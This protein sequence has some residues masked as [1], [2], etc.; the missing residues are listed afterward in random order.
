[1]KGRYVLLTAA[2]NEA[3]FIEGAIRSVAEQTILPTSWIIVDDG[4]SDRTLEIARG[5]A[6]HLPWLTVLGR[7]KRETGFA[8]KV[9]SLNWAWEVTKG[10]MADSPADFVGVVDADVTFPPLHFERLMERMFREQRLGLAGGWVCEPREGRFE[11]RSGNREH[12]VPG[13]CQ[14]FRWELFERMGGFLPL[15]WG[16]EDWAAELFIRSLGYEVRSFPELAVLHHKPTVPNWRAGWRTAFRQGR[17]D[18]SLGCG[19]LFHLARALRRI[20]QPPPVLSFLLRLSGYLWERT[21]GQCLLPAE[22]RSYFVAWQRRR[23]W[24]R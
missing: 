18:A 8:S 15:P 24:S 6:E 13:C 20:G 21:H 9:A 16:G 7:R 14:L 5:Y 11:A 3:R 2:H 4:S 10:R 22:V 23:L 17:M 12:S 19:F 1:M